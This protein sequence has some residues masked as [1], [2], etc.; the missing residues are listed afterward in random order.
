MVLISKIIVLNCKYFLIFLSPT[1]N[2]LR[3]STSL[4][5]SG[6]GGAMWEVI[7]GKKLES[8]ILI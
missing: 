7:C 3:N 5:I 8:E 1:S 6:G 4:I 2:I